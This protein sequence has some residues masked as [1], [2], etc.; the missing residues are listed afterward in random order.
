[1]PYML[2]YYMYKRIIWTTM[3]LDV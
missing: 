1:M 2:T 3:T